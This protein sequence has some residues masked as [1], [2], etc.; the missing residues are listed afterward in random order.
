MPFRGRLHQLGPH[1][2]RDLVSIPYQVGPIDPVR[3]HLVPRLSA[4]LVYRYGRLGSASTATHLVKRL[5]VVWLALE[6]ASRRLPGT[7]SAA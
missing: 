4:G 6:S 2:V 7:L 5:C 3:P 1:V